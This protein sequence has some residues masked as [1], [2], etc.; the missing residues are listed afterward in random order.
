MAAYGEIARGLNDLA[1]NVLGVADAP[2]SKVDVPGARSF[3]FNAESDSDTLEGD[4]IIL[5]VAFSAKKGAGSMEM[6]KSNLTARAAMFGG[7]VVVSGTTPNE[8]NTWEESGA[9][10]QIYVQIRSQALSV[11]KAGSAYEVTLHKAKC[12]SWSES[13][14][15]SEWN[16]PSVDFEFIPNASD[17]FITRKLQETRVALA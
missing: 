8:V 13:M 7:T 5:A 11:D 10:N 17:K 15:V 1:V 2:G 4:D 3:E 14:G 16:T 12:G 6:G 9:A